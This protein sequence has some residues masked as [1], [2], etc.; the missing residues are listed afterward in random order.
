MSTPTNL[1]EPFMFKQMAALKHKHAELERD[2]LS[3]NEQIRVSDVAFQG[4][5]DRHKATQQERDKWMAV[6]ILLAKSESCPNCPDRGWYSVQDQYGYEDRT[7]CEWYYT[8]YNSRFNAVSAF[9]K[10]EKENK[11]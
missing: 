7:Q 9:D 3:L 5:F 10:L 6:A 4:E 2:N 11:Q 8:V 1:P